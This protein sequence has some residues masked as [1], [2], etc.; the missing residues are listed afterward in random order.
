[1]FPMSA[2]TL[3]EYTTH[4]VK[5][6]FAKTF[7]VKF[8]I[9]KSKRQLIDFPLIS[10]SRRWHQISFLL[11]G[12]IILCYGKME[13]LQNVLEG[14]VAKRAQ[15]YFTESARVSAGGHIFISPNVLC[16]HKIA[17]QNTEESPCPLVSTPISRKLLICSQL[18]LFLALHRDWSLVCWKSTRV[19]SADVRVWLEFYLQ[20][21]MW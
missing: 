2:V 16:G 15:H 10:S 1:M 19:W 13:N 17:F 21:W 5:F 4:K 20:L 18:C 12:W 6:L 8:S 7:R 3:E 14:D 11:K 9:L